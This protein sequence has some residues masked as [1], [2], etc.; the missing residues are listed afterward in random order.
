MKNCIFLLIENV[1]RK[2][3]FHLPS[4]QEKLLFTVIDVMCKN[5]CENVFNGL[6]VKCLTKRITEGQ[7][8]L[9]DL[10]KWEEGGG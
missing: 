8:R 10:D 1:Y 4:K 9:Q 3:I 6:T 7:G 2:T 5:W